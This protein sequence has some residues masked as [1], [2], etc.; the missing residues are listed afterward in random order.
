MPTDPKEIYKIVERKAPSLLGGV[1]E[2]QFLQIAHTSDG[3]SRIYDLLNTKEGSPFKDKM[4]ASREEFIAEFGNFHEQPQPKP[5]VQSEPK[6][7]INPT[8]NTDQE[9]SPFS[10]RNL[11]L[12]GTSVPSEPRVGVSSKTAL[13]E[14]A[15][16]K[17]KN[18]ATIPA[19]KESEDR[20]STR[21]NSS[22]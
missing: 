18:S 16:A 2:D 14:A 3:L 1:T 21:L 4:G 11:G 17:N 9:K 22:H 13:T 12:D 8:T 7:P 5:Q 6:T 15:N 20:K 10:P 19:T